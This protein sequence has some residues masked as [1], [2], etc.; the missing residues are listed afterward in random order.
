MGHTL[1]SGRAPP[2]APNVSLAR[3][4]VNVALPPKEDAMAFVYLL[5]QFTVILV[6]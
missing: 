5:L 6:R 4:A 1:N 2:M 3:I